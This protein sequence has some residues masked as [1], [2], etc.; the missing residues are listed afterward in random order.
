VGGLELVDF[1][2]A[3]KFVGDG[4]VCDAGVEEV[5]RIERCPNIAETASRLMPLL[6]DCVASV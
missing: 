5:M 2:A 3:A 1:A 4:A 6:M